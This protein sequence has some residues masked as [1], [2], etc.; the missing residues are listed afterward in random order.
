[1]VLT[2]ILL[3]LGLIGMLLGIVYAAVFPDPAVLGQAL[4]QQGVDG[5]TVDAGAAPAV[6]IVS[7]LV[8]FL[9]AVAVSVPLLVRGRIVVFWIPLVAGVI[10][11]INFWVTLGSV[12]LSNPTIAQHYGA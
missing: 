5:V 11:A 3:V 7:H 2:I 4:A 8:L 10:A 9:V 1:V 12:L 6:L